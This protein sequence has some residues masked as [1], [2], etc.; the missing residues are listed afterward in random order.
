M[1]WTRTDRRRGGNGEV[2]TPGLVRAHRVHTL[3][4]MAPAWERLIYSGQTT[5]NT[6]IICNTNGKSVYLSHAA[7]SLN[8][9][10]L[11]LSSTDQLATNWI[12]IPIR[13]LALSQWI[14]RPFSSA[15]FLFITA[16]TLTTTTW[17]HLLSHSLCYTILYYNKEYSCQNHDCFISE[18][19][20]EAYWIS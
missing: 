15:V 14:Q 20:T 4:R 7:E 18:T 17:I 13:F 12:Q 11:A 1:E 2:T 5:H 19:D 6:Q 8:Q 16:N 3:S 9:L 10:A